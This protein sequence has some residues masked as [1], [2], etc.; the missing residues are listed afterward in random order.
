VGDSC[1]VAAIRARVEGSG[2]LREALRSVA[3]E[4]WFR[5][6]VEGAP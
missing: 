2:S 4:P 1:T 5:E 3:L 6:K